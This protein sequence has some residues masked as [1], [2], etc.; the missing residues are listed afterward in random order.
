AVR[1]RSAVL[2]P[3][4]HDLGFRMTYAGR[5]TA[6]K[7]CIT[8][9]AG[10]ASGSSAWNLIFTYLSS[11]AFTSSFF[12]VVLSIVRQFLHHVAHM[13]MSTGFCSRWAAS[14]PSARLACQPVLSCSST[15]DVTAD[16]STQRFETI[17]YASSP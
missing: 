3:S 2:P 7:R 8:G 16:A 12:S 9:L 4:V 5:P 1:G 17:E 10:G 14:R 11:A 15:L 13:S 6:L